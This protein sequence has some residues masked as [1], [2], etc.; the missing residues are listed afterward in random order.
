MPIS[1]R[2]V[3]A[4]R[5]AKHEV[6]LPVRRPSSE[7]LVEIEGLK[8]QLREDERDL[9]FTRALMRESPSQREAW[10]G[11]AKA[12]KKYKEGLIKALTDELGK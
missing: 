10:E 7:I 1:R 6:R 2:A 11:A 12:K 8:K 5:V 4:R 3:L 9:E